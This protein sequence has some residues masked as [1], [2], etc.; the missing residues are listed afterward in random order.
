MA[1][2]WHLWTD[3][4]QLRGANVYQRRVFPAL[5]ENFMGPG[6]LGPPYT[7]TD[8]DN[9]AASGANWVNLSVPGLF[10]VTPPYQP[11]PDIAAKVDALIQMAAKARLYVVLSARTGPGRS[12]FSLLRDGVGDWFGH[13]YLIENVWE[14]A[15]ARTAWAEMW[16]YTAQRYRDNPVIIGYNLMV[17]PNADD[18]VRAA[19]PQDFFQ[20]Y[21][22]TGYDWNAWYPDLIAAIR[23]VDPYTPV[24]AEGLGYAD[25]RWLPYLQ[26]VNDDRVVY[27]FHQ[28]RPFDYVFQKPGDRLVYPGSFEDETGYF[29]ANRKWLANLLDTAVAV[30][31][32]TGAPVIANEIGVVR[33]APGAS[34]FM[35]DQMDLLEAR[36]ISYAVW[37]WYPTW[38][39]LAPQDNDFNFRFG[40]APGHLRNTSN[41]LWDTYQNFWLRN[42]Q[43]PAPMTETPSPTPTQENT[44]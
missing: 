22:G 26:P 4:T 35:Q 39:P 6:P 9:L 27:A 5:D 2:K 14:D 28:Y 10:T 42:T 37:L 21:Q 11:D 13:E 44:P 19:S 16:R 31:Q 38:P 18:L 43:R 17:E 15:Q 1:Y 24:L 7:Q 32:H 40:P 25:L 8:F 29:E 12:E 20:H 30:S 34:R 33:W 41:P 3:G 23:E 36:G